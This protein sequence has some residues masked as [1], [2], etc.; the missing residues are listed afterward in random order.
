[1]A[2]SA[3]SSG[4]VFGF[5]NSWLITNTSNAW[6]EVGKRR[7]DLTRVCRTGLS[8]FRVTPELRSSNQVP[9][10]GSGIFVV[11]REVQ[12]LAG[13]RIYIPTHRKKTRWM[14]HPFGRGGSKRTSNGK[15]NRKSF[16]FT[17]RKCA[18]GFAQND[19]SLGVG[20]GRN[21]SLARLPTLATMRLS[22]RWGT[23]RCWL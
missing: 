12:K 20:F 8:I 7:K 6:Q 2:E 22:R 15:Y 17:S 13:E 10:L 21:G 16:D 1:M 11:V 9:G 14:G 4:V 3:R 19:N 23:R 5:P 18:R